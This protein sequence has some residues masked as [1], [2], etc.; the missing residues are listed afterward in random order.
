MFEVRV[1][2]SNEVDAVRAFYVQM[3]YEMRGTDFDIL[4]DPD[5]HPSA[6]FLRESVLAGQVYVG[7]LDDAAA[8]GESADD[9]DN[10]RAGDEA[11]GVSGEDIGS[12]DGSFGGVAG[13]A[14]DG[15][16]EG[17]IV[18]AMVMNEEGEP[19]Y[20][21]VPWRVHADHG[22]AWIVH[23]LGTL[24]EFGGRGFAR[25][26]LSA[27]IEAARAAGK[28]AVRL[29]TFTYNTRAQHLYESQGFT[30]IGTF[31]NFYP[32]LDDIGAVVYEYE[33]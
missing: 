5:V 31:P 13:N 15:E 27:G 16:V 4:W 11:R 14:L 26:L 19:D 33:L 1:A 10:D 18:C 28:K 8:S 2:R 6:E 12:G 29:D 22:E 30:R 17:R 32:D 24:P 7:V 25:Q 23:V 20:A 3:I 9:A 21:K